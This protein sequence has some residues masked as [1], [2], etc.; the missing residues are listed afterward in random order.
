MLGRLVEPVSRVSP[1]RELLPEYRPNLKPAFLPRPVTSASLHAPSSRSGARSGRCNPPTHSQYPGSEHLLQQ[2]L[3][4]TGFRST[5]SLSRR[6]FVR[7]A[8]AWRARRVG[9]WV[10]WWGCSGGEI[11]VVMQG[12]RR[13]GRRDGRRAVRAVRT[14]GL[15]HSGS[16]SICVASAACMRAEG[17]FTAPAVASAPASAAASAPKT[18]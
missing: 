9:W 13:D 3:W 1:A 8:C 12:G 7:I 15:L 11:G 10:E 14:G 4:T 17:S 2:P 5:H 18:R 6:A 16:S